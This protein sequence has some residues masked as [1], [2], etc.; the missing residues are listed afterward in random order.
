VKGQRHSSAAV[1]PRERPGT[2]STGGWVGPSAGLQTGAE[3]L[4]P[5]TFD[6]RSVQPV[7]T[8]YTDYETRPTRTTVLHEKPGRVQSINSTTINSC[9]P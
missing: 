2:H 5:T 7:A 6:P 9:R 8:R 3:Y 1:Y 4:A